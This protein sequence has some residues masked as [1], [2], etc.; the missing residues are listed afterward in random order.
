MHENP[1]T[2][3]KKQDASSEGRNSKPD[4]HLH[5]KRR[6]DNATKSRAEIN[7]SEETQKKS[8]SLNEFDYRVSP[9][10]QT[11]GRPDGNRLPRGTVDVAMVNVRRKI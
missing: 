1:L 5:H 6:A 8:Y 4:L 9:F 2:D 10:D 3:C 11:E 7:S